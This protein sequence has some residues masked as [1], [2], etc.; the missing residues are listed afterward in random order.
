[1]FLLAGLGHPYRLRQ[2]P[3]GLTSMTTR[4]GA[5]YPTA[6]TPRRSTR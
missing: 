6:L 4:V 3:Y 5:A 1:M 2:S